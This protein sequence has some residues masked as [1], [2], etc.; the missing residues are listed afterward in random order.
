LQFVNFCED[1]AVEAAN[2]YVDSVKLAHSAK[3][4]GNKKLAKTARE[5]EHYW[6]LYCEHAESW[7]LWAESATVDQILDVMSAY[8]IPHNATYSMVAHHWIVNGN[9]IPYLE[10]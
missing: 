3:E 7:K 1:H 8:G 5:F 4:S 10:S 2:K 6:D 9:L